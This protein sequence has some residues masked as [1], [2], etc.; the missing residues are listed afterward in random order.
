MTPDRHP[1]RLACALALAGVS[2]IDFYTALGAEAMS[3]WTVY[4]L[5]GASL[6][7]LAALS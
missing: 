5:A 3:E 6:E 7:G 4:R 1:V 2:A